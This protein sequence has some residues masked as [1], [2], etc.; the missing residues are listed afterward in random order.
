MSNRLV[1]RY[2]KNIEVF[3]VHSPGLRCHRGKQYSIH[4]KARDALKD[5][6][7]SNSIMMLDEIQD[8]LEKEFEIVCSIFTISQCLKKMNI[9][10]K[11]MKKE[12][13]K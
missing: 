2:R 3:G 5:L 7:A 8:W 6:L 9:S 12:S 1:Q 4:L 11:R 13:E 10:Y